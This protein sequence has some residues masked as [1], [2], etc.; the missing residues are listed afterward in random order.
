MT[1][2]S[3]IKKGKK[4]KKTPKANSRSQPKEQTRLPFKRV[5]HEETRTARVAEHG[6][7]GRSPAPAGAR[8]SAAMRARPADDADPHAFF[9]LSLFFRLPFLRFLTTFPLA[10]CGTGQRSSLSLIQGERRTNERSRNAREKRE[11]E[12]FS[13]SRPSNRSTKE[14]KRKTNG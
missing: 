12:F 10:G 3:S 1:A 2:S 11:N 7:L 9:I 8:D 6:F 14:K 13:F 5:L 4:K